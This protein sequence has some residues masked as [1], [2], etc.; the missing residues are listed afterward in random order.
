MKY[1]LY[2]LK[3]GTAVHFGNG[4]LGSTDN[5]FLADRLFSALCIEAVKN[6]GSE[7]AARLA[8]MAKNNRLLFSDGM[9]YIGQTLY[10]PKPITHI[11]TADSGN[12]AAKKAFKKLNFI[13]AD[14]LDEYMNGRLDAENEAKILSGL[15]E[16]TEKISAAVFENDDTVPYRIGTYEFAENCGLYFILGYDG[17]EVYDFADSLLYSLQYEGIGGKVTSGLGK[18]ITV[19]EDIPDGIAKRLEGVHKKYMS[20]SVCMARDEQ[21]EKAVTG[22]TYSL[23]KRSGFISSANYA[24]RP[25]KK[26]TIYCF[27]AGSCFAERFEGDVFDLGG[28]GSHP[29]YR[30]AK[31][32]L[33]GV[34]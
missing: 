8:D 21:L 17:G 9:P 22:A 33:M 5:V 4:R 16:K 1:K 34:M 30:Y 14:K 29:V 23:V 27:T 24:D 31:P 13:P 10:I 3:F 25:L 2:R 26:R 19:T 7:G 15:G 18:F 20:L 12:S 6:Y 32:M 28:D 11:E